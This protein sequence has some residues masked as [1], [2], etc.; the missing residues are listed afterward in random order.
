MATSGS[1]NY[2]RTRNDLIN[3]SLR[4]IQAIGQGEEADPRMLTEAADTLNN[5]VMSFAGDGMPL[6]AIKE[7]AAVTL[8]AGVGTYNIGIGQTINQVAPLRMLQAWLRYTPTNP[9]YDIEL[10]MLTREEYYNLSPKDVVGHPVN[11]W[12]EPYTTIGGTELHGKL[13][14]WPVPDATTAATRTLHFI[15]HRP[16]QDF[17]ASTDNPDFPREWYEAIIWGLAE[18][19]SYEYGTAFAERSMIAKKAEQFYHRALWHGAQEGS[20]FIQPERRLGYR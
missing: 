20:M 19:L 18:R 2:A 17:D 3:Q 13:I 8:T 4:I 12:H 11:I 9:D 1:Y 6:W 16:Y 15:Y 5:M 7:S 14:L 10:N